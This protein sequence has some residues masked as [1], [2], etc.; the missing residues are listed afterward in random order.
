MKR[1]LLLMTLLVCLVLRAEA[2]ATTSI[3]G[4]T[5]LTITVTE[6]GD[7]ATFAAGIS[8]SDFPNVTRVNIVGEGV[9]PSADDLAAIEKFTAINILD[10]SKVK[11]EDATAYKNIKTYNYNSRKIS[12]VV[13]AAKDENDGT[14]VDDQVEY[15]RNICKTVVPEPWNPH[16]VNAIY[17]YNTNTNGNH[18]CYAIKTTD[19]NSGLKD[20]DVLANGQDN[21]SF[22]S[23]D[24]DWTPKNNMGKGNSYDILVKLNNVNV[25]RLVLAN[26]YGGWTG[27]TLET[28]TNPH[29]KALTLPNG[30][31]NLTQWEDHLK[32]IK[33]GEGAAAKAFMQLVWA[34]SAESTRYL[35][36]YSAEAG[37]LATFSNDHYYQSDINEAYKEVYYG[38]IN[39]ED[40]DFF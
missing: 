16:I 20:I 19:D 24:E 40:F 33:L 17:V 22:I 34:Y 28:F 25:K 1:A 14:V 29:V 18:T 35:Y 4:D 30:P 13:A 3:E 36:G 21:L 23:L 6:A 9:T 26:V 11:I 10:L 32:N 27:G 7:V 2:T 15:L 31:T 5:T 12:L 8:T 38:N 37:A 39:L